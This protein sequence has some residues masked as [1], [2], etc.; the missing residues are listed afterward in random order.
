MKRILA[1]KSF[2]NLSIISYK[3][4]F[5]KMK[6]TCSLKLVSLTKFFLSKNLNFS[7]EIQIFVYACLIKSRRWKAYENAYF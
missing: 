7:N 2:D 3:F 5:P 6:V 4:T 1:C